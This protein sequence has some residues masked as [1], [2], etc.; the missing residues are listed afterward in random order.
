MKFFRYIVILFAGVLAYQNNARAQSSTITSIDKLKGAVGETVTIFGS[1]FGNNVNDIQV[2]FGPVKVHVD[3]ME[4]SDNLLK[5]SVPRGATFDLIR[6]TRLSSKL[7]TYSED[8]FM[9]SYGGEVFENAN[10]STALE[11]SPAVARNLF[12]LCTCDL[13]NDGK[14]DIAVT[15]DDNL[16]TDIII[17]KNTSTPGNLSFTNNNQSTI[18]SLQLNS[19][20][21]HISCGD[22]N[23]DGKVDLI[24]SKG[25]TNSPNALFVLR[26]TTVGGVLSF[27]RDADINLPASQVPKKIEIK[28]LDLDGKS[29]IIISNTFSQSNK[30]YIYKNASTADAITFNSTAI[31]LS[32]DGL[33]NSYGLEAVDL[34][35]DGRPEIIVTPFLDKSIGIFQNNSIP[36]SIS[37]LPNIKVF[38]GQTSNIE[39]IQA[40]DINFDGLIDLVITQT[41]QNFVSV[42][43]NASTESELAFKSPINRSAIVE[44]AGLDLADLN[45]DGKLD[46]IVTNQKENELSAF[47]NTTESSTA[48]LSFSAKSINKPNNPSWNVLANDFDGDGKP[49]IAY[50]SFDIPTST[51]RVGLIRNGNC[52]KPTI[53]SDAGSLLLCSGQTKRLTAPLGVGITYEW[54]KEGVGTPLKSGAENFLDITEAGNYFVTA[55]SEGGSCNL[56]SNILTIEPIGEAGPSPATA[57][58]DGAVCEGADLQLLASTVENVTYQWTGPNGYTSTLQNPVI[59]NITAEQAGIYS[60]RTMV[61]SC[62]S[63]PTETIAEVI[64]LPEFYITTNDDL[65]QCNGGQATLMVTEYADFAYQ[66]LKDGN[67]I[68][69]EETV[70]LVVTQQGDYSVRVS[71]LTGAINCQ[72][73]TD[74]IRVDILPELVASIESTGVAC[75]QTEVAFESTTIV[76]PDITSTFLWEFD[77]EGTSNEENPTH[78]YQ[79]AGIYTVKLTVSYPDA[80]CSDFETFEIEIADKPSV[81]IESPSNTI[82]AGDE[83]GL[84]LSIDGDYAS[85]AWTDTNPIVES[86]SYKIYEAGTYGVVV[87]NDL[88]CEGTDQITI[89]ETAVPELDIVTEPTPPVIGTG[90]SIS[91]MAVPTGGDFA[92]YSWS[93]VATLSSPNQASTTA[94]PLDS[95]TYTV[96]AETLE[97]C[98]VIKKIKVLV[99]VGT[100]VFGDKAFS[101]NGDG[102][103][104]TWE[105]LRKELYVDCTLTIYDKNGSKVYEK[106][107]YD[108]DWDGTNNG[109]KLN[110]GV[111]YYVMNCPDKKP[112]T[113]SILL[114]K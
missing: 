111:Y 70:S 94:S 112:S 27:V 45:G 114:V 51:Y 53:T 8:K 29:D 96:E 19:A 50:T 101:P 40:G 83:I 1:G 32:P 85:I 89:V 86:S 109:K 15:K 31:E 12:D 5:V 16:A 46:I 47:I 23:G 71:N 107:G 92:T 104:D 102:Q 41:V 21:S 80:G 62:V 106:K 2:W 6:I 20:T 52:Y 36:G 7:S 54:K 17:L 67:E 26:N 63:E 88:G 103:N 22:L 28:D 93:P 56:N 66:W 3:S 69:N 72:K 30:I 61:S 55:I 81:E 43:I 68:E 37:F 79:S 38:T 57:S 82:C 75:V 14:P 42:L 49:D 48:V 95:V 24:I 58:T 64:F 108:N 13:D 77:D 59:E 9:V 97:G 65:L 34:N 91:L 73:T 4:V 74:E 110:P 98:I 39:N 44:P 78:I 99:E 33:V 11:F 76:D 100:D 87:T 18:A 84:I 113:G 35:N 25:G 60:V 10:L 90:E 105:L